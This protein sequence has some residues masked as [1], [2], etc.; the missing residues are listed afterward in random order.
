MHQDRLDKVK[1]ILA[2][3]DTSNDN[4]EKILSSSATSF[5]IQDVYEIEKPLDHQG[6]L[7]P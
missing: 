5:R 1:R 3:G 4:K 2:I 7:G 6:F